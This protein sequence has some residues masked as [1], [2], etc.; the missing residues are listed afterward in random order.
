MY[1]KL[2]MSLSADSQY[3]D[4]LVGRNNAQRDMSPAYAR[5]KSAF[6]KRLELETG[7]KPSLPQPAWAS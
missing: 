6:A 4:W 3:P 1:A 2:L 7:K 5:I